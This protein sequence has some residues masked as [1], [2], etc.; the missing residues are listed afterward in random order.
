M[1]HFT[2]LVDFSAIVGSHFGRPDDA[3]HLSNIGCFGDELTLGACDA[4]RIDISDAQ[5]Y[6]TVAGVTCRAKSFNTTT[7]SATATATTTATATPSNQASS[8]D[9]KTAVTNV[10]IILGVVVLIAIVAAVV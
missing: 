6:Q 4:T 3:V 8:S 7:T 2:C 5:V 10:V 1:S 9:S